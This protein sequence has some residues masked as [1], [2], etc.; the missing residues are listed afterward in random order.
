[1]TRKTGNPAIDLLSYFDAK[2]VEGSPPGP[3]WNV[4]PTRTCRLWPNASMG[5]TIDRRLLIAS[6][7]LVPSWAK[8]IKI[9]SKFLWTN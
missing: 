4:A 7:G 6:W 8:D 5:A 9:G 1:M 2:E 3:S